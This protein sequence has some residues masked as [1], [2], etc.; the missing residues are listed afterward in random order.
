MV[1]SSTCSARDNQ[2]VTVAPNGDEIQT[3]NASTG[4]F[5]TILT[6][7]VEPMEKGRMRCHARTGIK[8]ATPNCKGAAFL[9][10]WK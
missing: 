5:I 9:F 6:S 8:K 4:K 10:D 1:V 3:R 2:F 7:L